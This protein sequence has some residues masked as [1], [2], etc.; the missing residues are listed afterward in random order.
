MSAVEML[1]LIMIGIL[2]DAD[3]VLH[4]LA[5]SGDDYLGKIVA[6]GARGGLRC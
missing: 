4:R 1:S 5:H 2:L 3:G 6:F